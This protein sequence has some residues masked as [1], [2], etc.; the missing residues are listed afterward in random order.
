MNS[1]LQILH[2]AARLEKIWDLI[3]HLAFKPY[4]KLPGVAFGSVAH[5]PPSTSSCNVGIA[6]KPASARPMHQI[7]IHVATDPKPLRQLLVGR[8]RNYGTWTKVVIPIT[9]QTQAN[10][11]S[12]YAR[13]FALPFTHRGKKSVGPSMYRIFR[14]AF[15]FARRSWLYVGHHGHSRRE[16]HQHQQP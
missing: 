14:Q 10:W 4:D 15:A 8:D 1:E 9:N 2:V 7:H 5:L 16:E 12:A 6:L 3:W 13:Y 11:P